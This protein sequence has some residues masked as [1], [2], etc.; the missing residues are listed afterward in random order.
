[1]A[2]KDKFVAGVLFL[3]SIILIVTS[4]FFV[5]TSVK[6]PLQS[7]EYDVKFQVSESKTVGFDVNGTA[8]V[9]GRTYPGGTEIIRSVAV[10]NDYD[11]PIRVDIFL[12]ENVARALILNSS[13]YV[14]KNENATIDIRLKIPSDFPLGNYTGKIRLDIYKEK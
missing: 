6:E 14:K 3:V 9:F 5:F 11:F 1:M 12:S 2:G 7:V 10:D 8:L 13:Y 4:L